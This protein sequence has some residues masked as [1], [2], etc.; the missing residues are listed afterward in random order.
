MVGFAKPLLE[1]QAKREVRGDFDRLKE[2]L[3]RG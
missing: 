1:R 3:E 2:L